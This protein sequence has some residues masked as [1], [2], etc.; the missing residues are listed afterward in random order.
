M[1]A[2]CNLLLKVNTAPHKQNCNMSGY[3]RGSPGRGRSPGGRG[4]GRSFG[5]GA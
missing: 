1:K 5:G 3:G 2:T 4:G